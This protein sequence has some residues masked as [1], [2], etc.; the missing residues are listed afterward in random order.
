MSMAISLY[1]SLDFPR[2]RR[3][4]PVSKDFVK[5]LRYSPLPTTTGQHNPR[6]GTDHSPSG[7]PSSLLDGVAG[8][9]PSRYQF[10]E[11]NDL[12]QNRV[13]C[14]YNLA[15]VFGVECLFSVKQVAADAVEGLES[16]RPIQRRVVPAMVP[17]A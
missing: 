4:W 11:L 6:K 5:V 16:M 8:V 10:Q 1:R 12:H 14:G 17:P 2:M 3:F 15:V 13:C 9:Q 7:S